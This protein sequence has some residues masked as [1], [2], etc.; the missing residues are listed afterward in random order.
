MQTET[1]ERPRLLNWGIRGRARL[2]E[3]LKIGE[4]WSFEDLGSLASSRQACKFSMKFSTSWNN[5]GLS[6]FS[7]LGVRSP[8]KSAGLRQGSGRLNSTTAMSS[9]RAIDLSALG[10]GR[11][12]AWMRNWI[13][14]SRELMSSRIQDRKPRE[15]CSFIES[16]MSAD[17]HSKSINPHPSRSLTLDPTNIGM[18]IYIA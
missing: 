15:R 17:S 8:Q 2:L 4:G 10:G 18:R 7:S 13:F 1:F 9:P 6:I 12:R 14:S 5:V 3:P 11:N 16:P